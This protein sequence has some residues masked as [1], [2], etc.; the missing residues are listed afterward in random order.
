MARFHVRTPCFLVYAHLPLRWIISCAR[1]EHHDDFELPV[2]SQELS[3]HTQGNVATNS[4]YS[5]AT[6]LSICRL[7]L[8]HM[9][10]A[11]FPIGDVEHLEFLRDA[12]RVRA[13]ANSFSW[14]QPSQISI[15]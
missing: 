14:S 9:L 4:A 2:L 7:K 15:T 3:P 12:F 13:I 6:R 1:G 10:F 5:N 11:D 8:F